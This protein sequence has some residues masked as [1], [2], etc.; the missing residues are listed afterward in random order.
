MVRVQKKQTHQKLI[1]VLFQIA[2]IRKRL[3][4]LRQSW[5]PKNIQKHMNLYL[6]MR[7][8]EKVSNFL[9]M[10]RKFADWSKIQHKV[11]YRLAHETLVLITSVSS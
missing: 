4:A 1:I 2:K 7:A 3:N 6:L 9:H 10:R 11:T 5:S 8:H